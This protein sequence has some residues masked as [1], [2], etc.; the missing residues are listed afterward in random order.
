MLPARPPQNLLE[1]FSRNSTTQD[2]IYPKLLQYLQTVG[3]TDFKFE[4]SPIKGWYSSGTFFFFFRKFMRGVMQQGIYK[5][6]KSLK[7][8][9]W[10]LRSYTV[11]NF[12]PKFQ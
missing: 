1:K 6:L 12:G 2:R 9:N 8:E 5:V 10:F 3:Y 11:L 7:L 4:V